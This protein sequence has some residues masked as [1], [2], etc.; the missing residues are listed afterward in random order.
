GSDENRCAGARGE[1]RSPRARTAKIRASLPRAG[2]THEPPGIYAGGIS[3]RA[4]SYQAAASRRVRPLARPLPALRSRVGRNWLEI[5]EIP[6]RLIR[7]V[8]RAPPVEHRRDPR[9]DCGAVV[10]RY[11]LDRFVRMVPRHA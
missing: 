9:S 2:T 1:A 6:V 10:I 4:R 7:T 8:L 11:K 3:V 5:R